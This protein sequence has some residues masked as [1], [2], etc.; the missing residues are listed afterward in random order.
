MSMQSQFSRSGA[1]PEFVSLIRSLWMPWSLLVPAHTFSSKD[2]GLLDYSKNP[3]FPIRKW[4]HLNK[5]KV[6]SDLF[7]WSHFRKMKQ[8]RK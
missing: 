6:G 1:G 8:G 7:Q 4:G 3:L 2:S 5:M